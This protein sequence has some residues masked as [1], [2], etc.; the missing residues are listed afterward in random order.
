MKLV[1]KKRVGG[2]QRIK[3][4]RIRITTT[5]LIHLYVKKWIGQCVA[6]NTNQSNL[7]KGTKELQECIPMHMVRKT[8]K[9]RKQRKIQFVGTLE[10]IVACAL[11]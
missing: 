2:L 5:S 9:L 8:G 6:R 3:R 1:Q 10:K 11:L 4:K 7:V